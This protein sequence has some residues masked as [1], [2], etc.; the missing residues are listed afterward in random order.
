MKISVTD[1]THQPEDSPM[2]RSSSVTVGRL[3]HRVPIRGF[4]EA[5]TRALT[6]TLVW[7]F[8]WEPTWEIS[9]GIQVR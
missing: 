1:I 7:S 6:T 2:S 3:H 4:C 5:H 9:L 8:K